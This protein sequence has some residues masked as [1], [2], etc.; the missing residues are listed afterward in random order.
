MGKKLSSYEKAFKQAREAGVRYFYW[1]D[2]KDGIR[3]KYTSR[4]KEEDKDEVVYND[5]KKYPDR[6]SS[7]STTKESEELDYTPQ[8]QTKREEYTPQSVKRRGGMI[9]RFKGGGIIQHD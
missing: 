7:Y 4:L 2:P 8:S 3:R 6:R 1:T 9:N 5:K